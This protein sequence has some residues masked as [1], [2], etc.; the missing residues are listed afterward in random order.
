VERK[1]QLTYGAGTL[2]CRIPKA[3]LTG[4]YSPSSIVACTDP[5]AEIARALANPLDTPPLSDIVHPNEKIIILLDD[6]TRATPVA[7]ILPP[8]LAELKASG[9]KDEDVTLLI[10]HGTHRLSS[11]EEVRRK[12]GDEVYGRFRIVQHQC[13]DEENQV[14]LGLT[15]RGTP[16][17]VNRLAVEADRRIGIG[18]IGPSPYAGYSGGSKLL[19]PGVASLDTINANHSL[20]V[21]G[22][23]QPGQVN[24]PCR[25][26]IE[27]AG[28]MLGLDMVVDVVL[29]QDERIVR[30][31]AGTPAR[32]FQEGLTLARQV[33]EVACPG[34]VDVAITSAYPYDIDLYQAVRAVEYAD[35]VVRQG[36]SI[37]LV[38][39]C[40]EGIGDEGFYSLM[41][42]RTKKPDDFLRDVVRRNG[43]VTFSVLGYCL[44]R[45]K[46]EKK[47]YIVTEG[48]PDA[49]LEAMGF[50]RLAS[51]QAGVDVLLEEHGPQAQVAVFPMGSSTIPV[52][53]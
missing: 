35:A 24:V 28:E 25:L 33:Y 43:L 21:L 9:V 20:V 31:F 38:T 18:H 53:R 3:N 48:I 2:K 34:E 50:H 26:D 44:A 22:F 8:L 29:G 51:L 49:A 16:V 46:A 42:D 15:S 6:H 30:T 13:T 7:Q 4:I 37:L 5:A 19:L 27:E 23:R 52:V 39:A 47:L 12:V 17:W 45:I 32:V 10:T 11:E 36:G 1:I 40:P 41:A 14:Y